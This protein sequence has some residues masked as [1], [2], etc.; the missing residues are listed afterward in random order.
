MP[1]KFHAYF[2]FLFRVIEDLGSNLRVEK[3]LPPK[4]KPIV[5][6]K[7]FCKIF[8]GTERDYADMQEGIQVP[9]A[10]WTHLNIYPKKSRAQQT[11]DTPDVADDEKNSICPVCKKDYEST[12]NLGWV[13]C[14]RCH[15][16]FHFDCVGLKEAP[17]TRKWFCE[18]CKKARA[19][20][21]SGN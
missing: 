19:V 11:E 3:V 13:Q 16:W 21:N 4:I 10:E 18:P 5:I 15:N 1:S 14:D 17:T 12:Q 8:R 20:P 9:P 7:Q 6:P 2:D